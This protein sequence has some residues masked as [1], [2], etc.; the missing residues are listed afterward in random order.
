MA[1]GGLIGQADP[2][3]AE[4]GLRSR[5]GDMAPLIR[6]VEEYLSLRKE[7]TVSF[8]APWTAAELAA[9]FGYSADRRKGNPEVILA[10]DTAVELGHPSTASLSTVLVTWH[11]GLVRPGRITRVGPDLDGLPAGGPRPFGQVVMLEVRAGSVPDP[12]ALDSAQYLLHRLPGYTVRSVPGKLWV[13]VS[14]KGRRAGLTLA[15][16]GAAL[17]AAYTGDFEEIKAAEVVFVTSSASDV[18]ALSDVA[19]EARIL[20]GRHKKLFLGADGEVECRELACDTCE[21]K[22]V[23]DNLRDIVIQRRA[24]KT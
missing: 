12:F 20:S 19:V 11:P 3:S 9:R 22:P 1:A 15:A 18:E 24:R 16:V 14:R 7:R 6:R 4:P 23:C 13:R 2:E 21:E 8:D 5:L 10:E 17:I